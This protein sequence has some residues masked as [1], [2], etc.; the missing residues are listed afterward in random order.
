MLLLMRAQRAASYSRRTTA[1]SRKGTEWI[2]KVASV[3]LFIYFFYL[4]VTMVG[5]I[6]FREREKRK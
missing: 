5:R 1:I 2:D 3:C 6:K 4:F